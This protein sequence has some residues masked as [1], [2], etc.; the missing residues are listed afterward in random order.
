MLALS[1]SVLD[2]NIAFNRTRRYG[3]RSWQ[4]MVASGWLTLTR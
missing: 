3:Q 2:A 4:L 1:H